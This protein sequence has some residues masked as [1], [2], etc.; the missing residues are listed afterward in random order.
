MDKEDKRL[1]MRTFEPAEIDAE[2][3]PYLYRINRLPFVVSEQC[4]IGHIEY[5]METQ[6]RPRDESG[7]WGYLQLLMCFDTAKWLHEHRVAHWDWLWVIGSQMWDDR[8]ESPGITDRGSVRLTFAWDAQ[9]WPKP[10]EDICAALEEF[11]QSWGGDT[12]SAL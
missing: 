9:Y 5:S 7:Q 11:G 1:V 8:A 12:V 4:C 2:F 10:S 6:Y 3:L